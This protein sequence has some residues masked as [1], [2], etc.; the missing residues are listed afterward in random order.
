MEL[1]RPVLGTEDRPDP[2][3]PSLTGLI[4]MQQTDV[5]CDANW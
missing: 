2:Q 4:A 5:E 3:R 1:R